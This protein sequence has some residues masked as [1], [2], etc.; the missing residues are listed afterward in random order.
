MV[1]NVES[2]TRAF[3]RRSVDFEAAPKASRQLWRS[4]VPARIGHRS[5]EIRAGEAR[6]VASFFVLRAPLNGLRAAQGSGAS[7]SYSRFIFI[8][9]PNPNLTEDSRQPLLTVSERGVVED[10]VILPPLY[11]KTDRCRGV[12]SG[13]QAGGSLEADGRGGGT[14]DADEGSKQQP[15]KQASKGAPGSLAPSGAHRFKRHA[16]H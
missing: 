7:Y 11:E 8:D 12:G 9:Y 16:E 3:R 2:A 5:P 14:D 4:M 6:F 15:A 1:D 13:E 10:T